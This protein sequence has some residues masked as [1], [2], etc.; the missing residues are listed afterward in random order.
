MG[1]IGR[2]WFVHGAGRTGTTYMLR[3]FNSN[4]QKYV[5]DIGLGRL[6]VGLKDVRE[7]D[8]D[9]IVRDLALNI[10]ENARTGWGRGVEFVFKQ[11]K[12]SLNTY[13]Y[14]T[15]MFGEPERSL[16]CMRNPA[17]YIASAEKKFDQVKMERLRGAY[18]R[19]FQLYETIGGDVIEYGP[20]LSREKVERYLQA[21]GF[22]ISAKTTERLDTFQYAGE[23]KPELVTADMQAVYD[24]FVADLST[25]SQTFETHSFHVGA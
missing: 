25:R 15:E 8:S 14:L 12:C 16:F 2:W 17:G 23:Q 10:S 24:G 19:S 21:I 7:I 3:L 13:D 18:T 6:L 20:N 5:S 22:P 1:L 11:A 9:R 4:A